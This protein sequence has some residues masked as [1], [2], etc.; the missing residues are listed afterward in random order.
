MLLK[1]RCAGRLQK[2]NA[3]KSDRVREDCE[4]RTLPRAT[5]C[6]G[7]VESE[8]CLGDC[9]RDGGEERVVPKSDLVREGCVERE[10]SRAA[11][12]GRTAERR[13]ERTLPKATLWEKT[14]K[15]QVLPK[16]TM[17]EKAAK[18]ESFQK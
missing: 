8:S 17:C 14:A 2:A 5:V 11:V 6:K 12:C 3:A 16:A 9:V 1:H 4:K 7:T 15:R 13:E 18:S 10:L